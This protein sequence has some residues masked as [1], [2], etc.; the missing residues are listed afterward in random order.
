MTALQA[1]I[2]DVDGTIA[3]TEETHRRAFNAAFRS[4]GLDWV[5]SQEV[6]AD[7][8][9][10]TGGKER[11]HHYI[12]GLDAGASERTRLD[13]LVPEIHRTKTDAFTDSVKAGR[14]Q[15]RPGIR[16]LIHESRAAG[17]AVAIAST[18]SAANVDALLTASFG[19]DSQLLFDAICTGD[20]VARKKPAPDIYLLVLES[21]GISSYQAL[22][23]EDSR[24]GVL[25][26]K[27]A[28]LFTIATPT[29]WTVAQDLSVADLVLASLGDP[30][31]PD[32][33]GP[34]AAGNDRDFRARYVGVRQLAQLHAA[35]LKREAVNNSI[36]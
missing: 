18:T 10:V 5:W 12:A 17:I 13:K 24:I 23:I 14:L 4:H 22:A 7:L 32:P 15:P 9:Q 8:L 21:I 30:D 33:N 27:A 3:D 28:G 26:A 34:V 6:Y 16:R 36:H 19:G 11:I 25:A 1:I 35:A 2:L 29:P 20:I 31:E